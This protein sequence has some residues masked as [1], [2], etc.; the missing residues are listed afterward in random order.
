MTNNIPYKPLHMNT[1]DVTKLEPFAQKIQDSVHTF[2]QTDPTRLN[3]DAPIIKFLMQAY[4]SDTFYEHVITPALTEKLNNTGI[5]TVSILQDMTLAACN[6]YMW[7]SNFAL[8]VDASENVSDIVR[9]DAFVRMHIA[10]KQLP[11]TNVNTNIAKDAL[12]HLIKLLNLDTIEPSIDDIVQILVDIKVAG[13]AYEFVYHIEQRHNMQRD[14]VPYALNF[15]QSVYLF[16]DLNTMSLYNETQPYTHIGYS[17]D[18]LHTHYTNTDEIRYPAQSQK[19]V[20]ESTLEN[21]FKHVREVLTNE[22]NNLDDAFDDHALQAENTAVLHSTLAG[23][24]NSIMETA[25]HKLTPSDDFLDIY[26]LVAYKITT[27]PNT[28]VTTDFHVNLK[29]ALYKDLDVYIQFVK[30]NTQQ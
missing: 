28:Y 16:E 14:T 8:E 5:N 2:M 21:P 29:A 17:F 20:H 9:M 11:T 12:M 6:P 13:F 4:M 30:H 23:L 26:Q 15:M 7:S 19:P 18:T 3:L 25:S 1:V 10:L 24:S 22:Y 27:I